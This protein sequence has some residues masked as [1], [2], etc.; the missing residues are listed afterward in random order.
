MGVR[1]SERHH[2]A[3]P[4]HLLGKRALCLEGIDDHLPKDRHRLHETRTAD[5]IHIASRLKAK[6]H[7][8]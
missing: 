1:H 4:I 5:G 8:L 2:I 7:E 6:V 3:L